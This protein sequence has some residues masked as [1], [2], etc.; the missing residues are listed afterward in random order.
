[1][2]RFLPSC[3]SRNKRGNACGCP[4]AGRRLAPINVRGMRKLSA[5]KRARLGVTGGLHLLS[6]RVFEIGLAEA[7][8]AIMEVNEWEVFDVDVEVD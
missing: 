4:L 6:L 2:L 8:M 1:M 7:I 5:A 3:A